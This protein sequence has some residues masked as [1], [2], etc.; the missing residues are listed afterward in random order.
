VIAGIREPVG[1]IERRLA[2]LGASDVAN[3]EFVRQYT[4]APLPDDRKSVSFRITAD[5]PDRTLSSEDVGAIRSR[6]IDG[7]QASG[8]EL[9]L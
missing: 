5:A 9:R 7:M 8:Y 4:G 3:I 6:I 2:E 1:A